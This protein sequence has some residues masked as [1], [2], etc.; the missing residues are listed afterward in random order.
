MGY[1]LPCPTLE[2]AV[3]PLNTAGGGGV[4][5]DLWRFHAPTLLLD[6]ARGIQRQKDTSNSIEWLILRIGARPMLSTELGGAVVALKS[7]EQFRA[8]SMIESANRCNG[9]PPEVTV[10]L[11]RPTPKPRRWQGR[12][13]TAAAPDLVPTSMVA[14]NWG[15]TKGGG[16][17]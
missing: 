5:P 16:V 15:T 9:C 11:H 17:S 12:V 2:A 10:K 4:W 8:A 14:R 3:P 1:P 6:V 7:G 13:L